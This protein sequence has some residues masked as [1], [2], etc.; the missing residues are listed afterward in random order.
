MINVISI[1][2][3][4]IDTSFSRSKSNRIQ[5]RM[6]AQK[7]KKKKRKEKKKRLRPEKY[8]FYFGQQIIFIKY[9]EKKNH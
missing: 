4:D 5:S 8:T 2:N 3:L 1:N 7:S 9:I 6:I